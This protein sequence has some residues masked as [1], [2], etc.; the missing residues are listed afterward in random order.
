MSTAGAHRIYTMTLASVY[1]LYLA[2]V[3]KKGRTRDELDSVICWLTGTTSPNSAATSPLIQ[4]SRTS[5]R[6]RG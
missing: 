3:E 4:P 6:R 2:K 1:P 5:S